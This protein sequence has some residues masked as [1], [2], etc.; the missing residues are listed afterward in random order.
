MKG[1]REKGEP[2]NQEALCISVHFGTV[3]GR[4]EPGRKRPQ[5]IHEILFVDAFDPNITLRKDIF[6]QHPI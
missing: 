2:D 5:K 1:R 4:R 6:V 3:V